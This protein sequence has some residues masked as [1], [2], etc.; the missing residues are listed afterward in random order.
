MYDFAFVYGISP[1]DPCSPANVGPNVANEV[2]KSCC[3]IP[4]SYLVM[5]HSLG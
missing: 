3:R 2:Y 1:G 4:I 5:G